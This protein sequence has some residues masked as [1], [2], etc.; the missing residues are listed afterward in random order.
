MRTRVS[1]KECG[2]ALT[3]S[4]LHNHTERI[5]G[6]FLPQNRGVHIGRGGPET[7]RVY[8]LRVLKLVAFLVYA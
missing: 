8:F 2:R 1:C 4:S 3:A 5:Y 6:I 7:Y